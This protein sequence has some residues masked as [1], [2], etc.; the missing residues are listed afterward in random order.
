MHDDAPR[1]ARVQTHAPD[2]LR[3]GENE[4]ELSASLRLQGQQLFPLAIADRNEWPGRVIRRI[5]L[6]ENRRR[7]DVNG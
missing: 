6:E 1:R 3:I 4:R 2:K 5:S 7:Y